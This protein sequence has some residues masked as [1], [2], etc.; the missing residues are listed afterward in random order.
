MNWHRVFV[1]VCK[2]PQSFHLIEN[3]KPSK[4]PFLF[5]YLFHVIFDGYFFLF[6]DSMYSKGIINTCT[7]LRWEICEHLSSRNCST[8]FLCKYGDYCIAYLVLF[9]WRATLCHY[10]R[11]HGLIPKP[12]AVEEQVTW[13]GALL[14]F[15]SPRG[16]LTKENRDVGTGSSI[17]PLVMLK[18]AIRRWW[19]T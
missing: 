4:W 10:G 5:R 16:S 19:I 11:R 12:L 14:I 8:F 6:S 9:S 1:S 7:L 15:A 2:F 17:S 3:I 13:V 18:A